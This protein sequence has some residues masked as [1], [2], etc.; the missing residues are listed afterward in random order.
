MMKALSPN[1]SPRLVFSGDS[2]G[3]AD[4]WLEPKL[5]STAASFW[6]CEPP[7]DG[8]LARATA[9]NARLPSSIP[10][11]SVLLWSDVRKFLLRFAFEL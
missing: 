7:G 1:A 11:Q 2:L 9:G 3:N 8:L 4:N 6:I 5:R 10:S